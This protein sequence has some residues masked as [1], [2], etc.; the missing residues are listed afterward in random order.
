METET[1]NKE[2][3]GQK[4]FHQKKFGNTKS[5]VMDETL[6]EE[7]K[8]LIEEPILNLLLR[9]L[10]GLLKWMDAQSLAASVSVDGAHTYF[11]LR[12]AADPTD[13]KST[14]LNSSHSA[15]SRMPSS[16]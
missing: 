6:K 16:A 8:K 5:D 2:E 11:K 9:F 7:I 14:R 4:E 1:I 15:K 3:V 10:F 12:D 13:R